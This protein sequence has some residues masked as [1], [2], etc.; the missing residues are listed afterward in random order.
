MRSIPSVDGE[1]LRASFGRWSEMCDADEQIGQ[2]P[3]RSDI[4]LMHSIDEIIGIDDFNVSFAYH[5]RM[6]RLLRF[7]HEH[8]ERLRFL[9]LIKID[10][11]FMLY[12]NKLFHIFG[13][14]KIPTKGK[15]PF[16]NF[17]KALKEYDAN[18]NLEGEV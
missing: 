16:K 4:W 12:A 11:A 7:C 8:V 15:L 14:I 10:G 3:M 17:L 6:A 1:K 2:F 18:R 5:V 13:E 9:G